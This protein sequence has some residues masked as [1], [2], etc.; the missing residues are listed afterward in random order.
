MKPPRIN[1][2]LYQRK[3]LEGDLKD[4]YITILSPL[5]LKE[6]LRG[7]IIF[8][9]TNFSVFLKLQNGCYHQLLALTLS[10]GWSIKSSH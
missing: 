7:A 9:T 1:P 8:L 5:S 6:L 4:I 3:S 2:E 10:F